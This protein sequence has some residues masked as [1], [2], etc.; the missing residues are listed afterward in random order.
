MTEGDFC[1]SFRAATLRHLCN[2]TLNPF[3]EL[4]ATEHLCEQQWVERS[5]FQH[6]RLLK[7]Q[8]RVPATHLFDSFKH[9]QLWDYELQLL[10]DTIEVA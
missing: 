1:D 2:I 9:P 10:R 5:A 4:L 6:A 8:H 3:F 7:S